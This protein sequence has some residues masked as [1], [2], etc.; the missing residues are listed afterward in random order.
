[1]LKLS[2]LGSSTSR[3]DMVCGW[4]AVRTGSPRG[5]VWQMCDDVCVVDGRHVVPRAWASW[6][7]CVVR[8]RQRRREGEGHGPLLCRS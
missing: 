8:L 7:Q 2:A 3:G 4:V 6:P 1:M 5:C